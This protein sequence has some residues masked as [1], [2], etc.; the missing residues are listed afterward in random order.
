MGI[1][2]NVWRSG[3]P[4]KTNWDAPPLLMNRITGIEPSLVRG[5]RRLGLDVQT[6]VVL[7]AFGCRGVPVILLKGPTTADWLYPEGGREYDDIDLLVPLNTRRR[8]EEVLRGVGY[9]ERLGESHPS[10]GVEHAAVW[11]APG[12]PSVDM[13][14]TVVGVRIDPESAW[15]L[16]AQH[17]QRERVNGDSVDGLDIPARLVVLATHSA[18]HGRQVPQPMAD[19]RRGVAS[20]TFE[21]W[22]AAASLAKE[23]GAQEAFSAGLR[24][25]PDGV[26]LAARLGLSRPS[27]TEIALRA[28]SPP[29]MA[30]GFMRLSTTRGLA[31]KARLIVR[32]VFPSR[33]FMRTWSKHAARGGSGWLIAYASRPIWLARHAIPGLRAWF[34]ARKTAQ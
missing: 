31:A 25:V 34:A 9:H 3:Q 23:L 14:W 2:A 21:Q 19:L 22:T 10:E 12:R 5:A 15:K 6:T 8:A 17:I 13:H 7:R 30:M 27:S 20:C 33:A 16:W 18:A 24:L 1:G 4:R 26:D 29:H 28:S 32:E 11:D